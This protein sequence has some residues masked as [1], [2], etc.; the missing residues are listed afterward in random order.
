M[1]RTFSL[2]LRPYVSAAVNPTDDS[3]D[4]GYT[5]WFGY[6]FDEEGNTDQNDRD[7]YAFSALRDSGDAFRSAAADLAWIWISSN[8]ASIF[9]EIGNLEYLLDEKY[10]PGIVE[11]VSV[12]RSGDSGDGD[13]VV[14]RFRETSEG[15]ATPDFLADL[16]EEVRAGGDTWDC[17]DFGDVTR[18]I[19]DE[20]CFAD[21]WDRKLAPC[22]ANGGAASVDMRVT[23]SDGTA[24]VAPDP[25]GD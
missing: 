4:A 20:L 23:L 24:E 10:Q 15:A 5:R 9:R 7:P 17:G 13:L 16:Q 3:D 8:G 11:Y 21:A 12:E 1:L 22:V 19:A 25:V 18:E 6:Y 14:F 2:I